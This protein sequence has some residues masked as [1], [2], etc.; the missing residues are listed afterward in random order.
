MGERLTESEK[1]GMIAEIN[2]NQPPFV[3]WSHV[4]RQNDNQAIRR[5]GQVRVHVSGGARRLPSIQ[6]NDTTETVH[7]NIS[8]QRN[9]RRYL[10]VSHCTVHYTLLSGSEKNTGGR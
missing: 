10:R 5:M 2:R 8:L 4:P 7:R 3:A 9:K 1:E 6:A